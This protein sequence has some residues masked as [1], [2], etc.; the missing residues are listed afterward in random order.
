MGGGQ[1]QRFVLATANRG[2]LAEFEALFAAT[3]VAIEALAGGG[4]EPPAETGLTFVENALIK[5]RHAAA[6]AGLPAI[7]DDSGLSV[8]A[9][10]GAPGVRSARFAGPGASDRDNIARLL[11][12]LERADAID[13]SA[14]FHCVI[15]ALAHP[16]DPAPLIAHGRWPGS[17]T[18]AARGSRGFGYDPVFLDPGLGLTAAELE[19]ASKNAISHRGRAVRE[20][21]RLLGHAPDSDLPA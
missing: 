21:C 10:G 16:E 13:R 2:K 20:L 3:P 4:Y 9:L 14:A 11:D 15:V 6:L 5:A 18:T 17:I 12:E 1:P 19:P 8:A 7:A